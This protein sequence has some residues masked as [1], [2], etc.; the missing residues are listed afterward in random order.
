MADELKVRVQRPDGRYSRI[1]MSSVRQ[2][3]AQG[4]V[5]SGAAPSKPPAPSELSGS[6]PPEAPKPFSDRVMS[7]ISANMEGFPQSISTAIEDA[8]RRYQQKTE[9]GESGITAAPH[10]VF[11]SSYNALEGA[12]KGLYGISTP[13]VLG[14]MSDKE[15]P[16][17]IAG[18]AAM[19]FMPGGDEALHA[20]E[21]ALKAGM[22]ASEKTL[23]PIRVL[24]QEIAGAG[25]EPVFL[26]RLRRDATE[27]ERI[28][29]YHEDANHVAAE[30]SRRL[31]EHS[32]KVNEAQA[33]YQKEL[34]EYQQSTA[35]K[36][37][38]H[39]DKVKK[40]RE[41]WV[42]QSYEAKRMWAEASRVQGELQSLRRGQEA[43]SKIVKDNVES[44]HAA[45]RQ[46]L[47]RRWGQLRE[48]V[49]PDTPVNS[50]AI[51]DAI[52]TA[53]D[54][55]LLGSPESLKVFN[56]LTKQMLG[57]EQLDAPGGIEPALRPLTWDEARVHYSALGDKLYSGELP[58]NVYRG[59]DYV[60]NSLDRELSSVAQAR[61]VGKAYSALKSDWSRYMDDWRDMRSLAVGGSPLA[62]VL[63]AQD[64][65][66]VSAQITGKAGDRMA[67][68]LGRYKQY[69]GN[70]NA[71]TRYRDL[72]ARVKA[73]PKV[74]V[75]SAPG[76]LELPPEPKLGDA[77]EAKSVKPP[78]L[79]SGPRMEP[80]GDVDPV[81][82]RRR[83]LTEMA[84]RPFRFYDLFPPYLLEHMA[85]KS[86]AIREWIATQARKELEP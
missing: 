13:G 56:D 8:R 17:N 72:G 45:V 12:G 64:P 32:A 51:R 29:R 69:G 16:A 34:A 3:I 5:L 68:T 79:Q 59:L 67:E 73:L 43:Y 23:T 84:G 33:A 58:G 2:A 19:T 86:P 57:E 49:G 78:K 83:K 20:A 55:F 18:D 66:F 82:I 9:S 36:K 53:K 14:R 15:D 50:V 40:A 85:L 35:E 62:R 70:P 28:Q 61:G 63:K 7:R 39:A 60:R 75:P 74:R 25:R 52:E 44:T 71:I 10:A 81:A 46:S 47:D 42:R 11:E 6:N 48:A 80:V 26:E 21:P 22:K 31:Q 54:K 65:G 27:K 37:A 77:P 4:Y 24:G 1:P 41:E 38:A 76:K 30:N